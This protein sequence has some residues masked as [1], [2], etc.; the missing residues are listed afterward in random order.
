MALALALFLLLLDPTKQEKLDWGVEA[1]IEIAAD[2]GYHGCVAQ[3]V[4]EDPDRLSLHYLCGRW[5]PIKETWRLEEDAIV[6]YRWVVDK[7]ELI[8][9]APM[10]G[11]PEYT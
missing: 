5:D 3:V 11:C 2:Y 4:D 8:S 10:L 6:R 1:C 9:S 7:F